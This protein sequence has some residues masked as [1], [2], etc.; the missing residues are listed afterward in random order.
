MTDSA[1]HTVVDPSTLPDAPGVYLYLDA[2]ETVIYVGKAK[3]LRKRVKSYF[4]DSE[5]LDPKTR[6]LM[7][8]VRGLRFFVVQSEME[9]L[10]LENSLIK[11]HMPRF[12]IRLKDD[13]SYPYIH[14][15]LSEEF[16]RILKSR[17]RRK[18]KGDRY[19]GPYPGIK[20]IDRVIAFIVRAFKICN[21]RKAVVSRK[22]SSEGGVTSG[23]IR[24]SAR[25][26]AGFSAGGN[27]RV[28][29]RGCLNFQMGRCLGPCRGVLTPEEY[30]EKGVKPALD[31]LESGGKGFAEEL[32]AGMLSSSER[33]DFEKAAWYRDLLA[34]LQTI[35]I[36]QHVELQ[37][38]GRCDV[39]ATASNEE[40]TVI[41][42]VEYQDGELSDRK[43][44]VFGA[45]DPAL[46][47]S[48]REFLAAFVKSYYDSALAL[49]REILLPLRIE[50]QELIGQWLCDRGGKRVI[51]HFP[52]R[53][54][55]R[56][57]VALARLNALEHLNRK[58]LGMDRDRRRAM[59]AAALRELREYLE[60]PRFPNRIVC[61]D[62]S[63]L[64]V[65]EPVAGMTCFAEGEKERDGFRKFTIRD[66]EGQDDFAMMR[67]AIGRF[68]AHVEAGEWPEPD[69]ILIDGGKGQLGAGLSALE[70]FSGLRIPLAS[71][72][73]KRE[74]IFVPHRNKPLEIPEN[75]PAHLLLRRIRD[76]THR[77]AVSFHRTRR[78]RSNFESL[79]DRIPG[80]GPSRRRALLIRF[81]SVEAIA[82]AG[83]DELIS[84]G[85]PAS[86]ARNVIDD[87]GDRLLA[88][89]RAAQL[90][91][92]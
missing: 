24:D 34:D 49:P 83:E 2:S 59:N 68:L 61:F 29:V 10:I 5:V 45:S 16:P 56:R 13:S 39:I 69:L 26:S 22:S 53:G 20:S 72:A 89:A 27:I 42:L 78:T 15:T 9:A 23:S 88:A 67:E 50:D 80:I 3:S 18:R 55:R 76:E 91:E 57:Q 46:T 19:F 52:E 33:L 36:R 12:N 8:S 73:K 1:I 79:L 31:F 40:I 75:C 81:G 54:I 43:V 71:I 77:Y 47:G 60:L 70:N 90:D 4:R 86:V 92:K 74:E 87:L 6:I 66:V 35:G 11:R 82:R 30:F 62:I 84:A 44:F 37:G 63:N 21:C 64:G 85:L 58:M 65:Q 17:P 7:S 28:N 25:D 51:L 14:V 38:R 32:R 48:E 41:A